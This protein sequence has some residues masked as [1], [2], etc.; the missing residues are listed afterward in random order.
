MDRAGRAAWSAPARSEA[1]RQQGCPGLGGGPLHLKQYHLYFCPWGQ[2]G[3]GLESQRSTVG[4][5][6]PPFV[7]M[8]AAAAWWREAGLGCSCLVSPHSPQ[9]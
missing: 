9:D 2:G 7:R 1:G 4:K 5:P 3:G 8:R 6:Q